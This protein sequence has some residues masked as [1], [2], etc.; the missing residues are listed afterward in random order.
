MTLQKICV[1][2]MVALAMIASPGCAVTRDQE[3]AASYVDDAAVTA[4]IKSRFIENRDVDATSIHVET[5]NGAVQ[6][7]GFAK[8]EIEKSTANRL[9]WKVKGVRSVKN[10]IIVRP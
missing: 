6:L 1:A 8:S 4:A 5:L 2:A 10:E 3:T 7:S 9:T